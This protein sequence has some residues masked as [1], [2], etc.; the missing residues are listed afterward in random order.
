MDACCRTRMSAEVDAQASAFRGGNLALYRFVELISKSFW[1]IAK[2]WCR[3]THCF[4]GACYLIP[5]SKWR[6]DKS[7]GARSQRHATYW[8]R[9]VNVKIE[10]GW[11]CWPRSIGD[12]VQEF[13]RSVLTGYLR[14][15]YQNCQWGLCRNSTQTQTY[16]NLS[17]QNFEG[18][19]SK[20]DRHR[21]SSEKL[22]IVLMECSRAVGL[23]S[24]AV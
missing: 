5:K 13:T 9:V 4:E 10:G 23:V 19:A 17:S 16:D 15:S 7:S 2:K 14:R 12:A 18:P 21:S 6:K 8:N 3:E 1:F 11:K 24:V 22:G 20:A